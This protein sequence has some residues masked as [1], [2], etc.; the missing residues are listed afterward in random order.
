MNKFADRKNETK[1]F[2]TQ[3]SDKW[4]IIAG[5]NQI[6]KT[7][8]VKNALKDKAF[9]YCE[10]RE[11]RHYSEAFL[12]SIADLAEWT[13]QF[14]YAHID[15]STEDYGIRWADSITK[16][17]VIEVAYRHIC[18]EIKTFKTDFAEFLGEKISEK[19]SFIVFDDY[20]TCPNEFYYQWLIHLT[21]ALGDKCNVIAICDFTATWE[22]V[23]MKDRYERFPQHINIEKFNRAEDYYEVL[24][25]N[26][27]F[28]NTDSLKEIS[29]SLFGTL[30]GG[31]DKLFKTIEQCKKSI[32]GFQRDS[33]KA[34]IV[35]QTANSIL[36]DAETLPKTSCEL[37]YVLSKC[38]NMLTV[39]HIAEIL[40]FNQS[41]IE[42]LICDLLNKNFIERKFLDGEGVFRLVDHNLRHKV[43]Y[44]ANKDF[45]N[46]KIL[47]AYRAK[48]INIPKSIAMECAAEVEDEAHSIFIFE[49]LSDVESDEKKSRYLDILISTYNHSSDLYLTIDNC[50]M[51]YKYGYYES[52]LRIIEALTENPD[53]QKNYQLLMLQGDVRHL[54]LHPKTRNSFHRAA[55]IK[56]ISE[57]ERISA[58]NREIMALTQG[59]NEDQ[60]E[61]VKLYNS[62]LDKYKD[63]KTLG[64]VE[65][66][67]N[68]NNVFSSDISLELTL[69][70]CRLAEKIGADVEKHKCIHNI[71]MLKLLK[72]K[73]DTC[74]SHTLSK[75]EASFDTVK[76]FFSSKPEFIHELAYPIL[77]LGTHEMFKYSENQ[78]MNHLHKA[79]EYYSEAQL[80]A[81]SFYALNIAE[82]GL[83]IVNSYLHKDSKKSIR[84]TRDRIYKRYLDE[85]SQK[86]DYRVHRKILLSL[87]MS[88]LIT[89]GS[90]EETEEYLRKVQRYMHG[91]EINRFNGLCDI[92]ELNLLKKEA[93]ALEESTSVYY[94]STIFVPWL[95]SFGH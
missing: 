18:S 90:K 93:P 88:S 60:E 8:F 45:L 36:R 14:F 38:P 27:Y 7:E 25:Q 76:A 63:S 28:E 19:Y 13:E 51:L 72:N 49:N 24:Y 40:E 68:S 46:Y 34:E 92:T 26:L 77:D 4:L 21:E 16:T 29:E 3:L 2:M 95:I 43:H 6:G 58:I 31:S 70:G 32:S 74:L 83:L 59:N 62:T 81:K 56:T 82:L 80:Y 69:E 66:Y 78:D 65:L 86:K 50:K 22:S 75:D 42:S 12:R 61:A 73:Y 55:E 37:L 41:G 67:R 20:H 89:E 30:D 85:V 84:E 52:A 35:L 33:D 48:T 9:L 64:L 5:G 11:G 1:K 54:L 91:F 87:A 47:N 53:C 39:N 23:Q 15:I 44:R 17:L 71:C 79:K 10:N 57:S 94:G